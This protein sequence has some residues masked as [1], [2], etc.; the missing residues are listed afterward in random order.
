MIDITGMD[1]DQVK[2]FV[3]SRYA[4]EGTAAERMASS[5]PGASDPFAAIAS[6]RSALERFAQELRQQSSKLSVAQVVFAL[7]KKI[8]RSD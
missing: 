3:L 8:R 4:G 5:V 7:S 1:Y 2:A 6:I